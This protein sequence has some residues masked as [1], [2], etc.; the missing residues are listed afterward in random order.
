MNS[1]SPQE[2]IRISQIEVRYLLEGTDTNGTLRAFRVHHP[3]QRLRAGAAPAR[4]LR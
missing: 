3:A 4:G 2:V 1:A